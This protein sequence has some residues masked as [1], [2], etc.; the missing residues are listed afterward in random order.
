MYASKATTDR[1]ATHQAAACEN[2]TG[3]EALE[4]GRSHRE[5]RAERDAG[6][7]RGRHAGPGA[8]LRAW[9]TAALLLAVAVLAPT[10]AS[11]IEF[12]SN[13]D[14]GGTGRLEGGQTP[15]AQR[16]TTGSHVAGYRLTSIKIVREAIGS[17]S[18]SIYTVDDS[19]FPD[20]EVATL[21]RGT[22]SGTRRNFTAPANTYLEADT[23]YA[24]RQAPASRIGTTSADN[25]DS[26]AAA[27]WTIADEYDFFASGRWQKS[28]SG[29]SLRIEINGENR[30]N[31]KPEFWRD[32]GSFTFLPSDRDA[33]GVSGR[34]GARDA[35]GDKLTY[36]LSGRDASWFD[37]NEGN[38]WI[39]TKK[40]VPYHQ[41]PS[42][43][44]QMTVTA[45]DGK[46][47]TDTAEVTL[48]K[49]QNYVEIS[50]HVTAP[51]HT[52]DQ[53]RVEWFPPTY[54]G[55]PI[56]HYEVYYTVAGV[57]G[58]APWVGENSR[59]ID[60][61][62]R[63]VL[64]ED[65]QP[66]TEYVV[67]VE[68]HYIDDPTKTYP[69]VSRGSARWRTGDPGEPFQIGPTLRSAAVPAA[70]DRLVLTFDQ[71]LDESA[72]ARPPARAFRGA[73]A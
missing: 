48:Y 6:E 37:I 51:E 29:M 66:D 46:G 23:T 21:S 5:L 49:R 45:D 68:A 27:G 20:T 14:Q 8:A 35:D 53:L 64:I 16:F 57:R 70:G 22:D 30:I 65:L 19:G 50:T 24:V 71:A 11:A 31:E 17:F 39:F 67:T 15:R 3:P 7:R 47:G 56:H 52:T 40:G 13:I 59:S 72:G 54:H 61:S 18:V 73:R 1:K 32:S 12:V 26:G 43:A 36:S 25:E 60:P 9:G 33:V 69:Y 4:R 55:R 28:T 62:T 44:Y 58:R 10:H 41:R 63:S 38:G 2:A 42:Q 34:L